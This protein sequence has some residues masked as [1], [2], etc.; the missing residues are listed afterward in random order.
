MSSGAAV[1]RLKTPVSVK[2]PRYSEPCWLKVSNFIKRYLLPLV[3]CANKYH[4][5]G[6]CIFRISE[7]AACRCSSE[8]ICILVLAIQKIAAI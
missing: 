2:A 8:K 1:L 6:D 4:T 7:S 5:M 3:I